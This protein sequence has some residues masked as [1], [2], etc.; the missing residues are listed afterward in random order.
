MNWIEFKRLLVP[1]GRTVQFFPPEP[2]KSIFP[3]APTAQP[4]ELSK[5]KSCDKSSRPPSVK[6]RHENPPSSVRKTR[7]SSPAAQPCFS[8]VKKTENRSV[9]TSEFKACQFAPPSSVCRIVP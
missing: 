9:L 7:P 6:R 2:V 8:S 4:C 5:K 1:E 3:R